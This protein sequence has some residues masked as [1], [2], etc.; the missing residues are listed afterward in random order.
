M[1]GREEEEKKY[2][3]GMK[4]VKEEATK[5]VDSEYDLDLMMD[6]MTVKS[7]GKMD[8]ETMRSMLRQELMKMG[9][10]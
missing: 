5:Y 4:S 8:P 3:I 10:Q 9:K 7:H 6:D 2:E 1:Y